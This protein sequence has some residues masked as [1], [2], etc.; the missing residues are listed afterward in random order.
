[1]KL[2]VAFLA[3]LETANGNAF[4]FGKN[5]LKNRHKTNVVTRNDHGQGVH[6]NNFHLL[7][8]DDCDPVKSYF[9][10][11]GVIDNFASVNEQG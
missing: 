11:G 4:G 5:R 7:S 6:N 10:N 1:M 3:V 2:L 8:S 9:Y